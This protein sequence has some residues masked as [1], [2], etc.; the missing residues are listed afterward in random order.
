MKRSPSRVGDIAEHYAVTWLW[1]NDYEVF[2]NCGCDGPI[3]IVAVSPQGEV[4]LI[5][6]KDAVSHWR[7]KKD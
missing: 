7:Y 3:D 4:K 5:E 1:D 2:M 6:C